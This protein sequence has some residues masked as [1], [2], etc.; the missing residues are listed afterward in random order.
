SAL[1]EAKREASV[2]RRARETVERPFDL[3]SGPLFTA[4]L[5]RLGDADHLLALATHH[6]VSDEWSKGVLLRE[7]DALYT[8]FSA[9]APSPLPAPALQ[10][11]DYAVWQRSWL[12][13]DTLERQVAYW[14]ERL[15][16]APPLLELPTD[17]PRP[18]TP[19]GRRA[20]HRFALPGE[21]AGALR[22]LSRREGATLFMTVFA[23]FQALL[24][25]HAG[26]EDVLVGTPVAGRG[27]AETEGL[28]G[29]FV[30]TLVLRADLSGDPAARALVAQTRERVL[31][32][33]THQDVPFE[34]LVD[35][36]RVERSLAHTPLFQVVF[37]LSG[38]RGRQAPRLGGLEVEELWEAAGETAFDLGLV[39]VEEEGRLVGEVDFRAALFDAATVERM[40]GHFRALLEGI[41]AHPER[42]VSDLPLLAPGER[43]QVV[44]G[45]G[46]GAREPRRDV[47]LHEWF[48]ERA[49]LAPDAVA[50]VDRGGTLTYGELAARAG[51]LAERLRA[52]GVGPEVRVG[53]CLERGAGAVAAILGV[54]TAG[55]AWVPLDPAYP[56][57]RL[58]FMLRDSGA[59]VVLTEA[60]LADRLP[61]FGGD[62][63]L[64]NGEPAQS[65]ALAPSHSPSPDPEGLAYVVY[66]SGSTGTPKGVMVSHRAAANLLA[67][68]L[69]DFGTG[70]GSRVLHAASLSFD[71]SVL[72]V[73]VALLAGAELH[74][75]DRETVLAAPALAALL[76]EHAIDTW[77]ATPALLESLPDADFPALRAV[78]TGGERCSA[79]VAARWSVGRRLV[80][81][82][83]PTETVVYT[84]RYPCRPGA[85]EAP[86]I[87]RPVENARAYVLD[88][89]G[90][91]LPAGVPGELYVG[92]AGVARGYLGRPDLTA[93]RFVPDPF[94]PEPRSGARAYRTGDRARW[95]PSGE[96]EFLGRVDR[97]VKLRG[98]RIEPGEVE[99]ALLA[100]PGVRSAA[101]TVRE[102]A[103]GGP[104]LV[105]YV[106]PEEGDAE[107]EQVAAWRKV[108]DETYE[109]AGPA[110]PD[111]GRVGW[112]PHLTP[113]E[114][115][116]EMQ[117]W[118]ERTAESILALKPERVLEIGCGAGLVLF[119]VAPHVRLYHATDISAVAVDELRRTAAGLPQ[120]R[121]GRAAADDL[122]ELAG[123]GFDTV[124]LNS[125]AQ[126][127][128]DVEYLLRVLEGAAAATGPG[129]R[130]FV[131][132]VH[133]LPLLRAFH[134]RVELA[135]TPDA[136]PLGHLRSR[137]RLA[138]AEEQELAID[139]ELFAALPRRIPR[140]GRV[141]VRTKRATHPMEV[142]RFSFDVVLHLDAAPRPVAPVLEWSGD[143]PGLAGVRAR[144]ES[145]PE[146]P[147]AVLGVPNAR[148][149]GDI[150]LLELLDAPDA[151]ATAGGLRAALAENGAPGVDPEALWTLAAELGRQVEIRPA[152]TGFLDVLFQPR[153]GTWA[154]A[155]PG[156]PAEA[157][158]WESYGNDPQRGRHRRELV[159]VLRAALRARLPEY[160]VPSAIV[161]L[162]AL[163]LTPT[164]KLDPGALPAP[165]AAAGAEHV[166][167][168]TPT[169]EILAGIFAEVLGIGRVGAHDNFFELGGHS[170]LAT[171][172]MARLVPA[173]GVELP[174]R[175]L[176]E[177]QTV[178]ELAARVEAARREGAAL[179]S[180]APPL[181]RVPRDAPLPLSF[182]QQR[183][184]F[185]D[186]LEPGSSAYNLPLALRLRGPLDARVLARTVAEIV[187]RHESLRTV[188]AEAG[189]EPVQVVLPAGPGALPVVDLAGLAGEAREAE[190]RRWV[191]EEARRPFDLERG[192]LLRA[193][194]LR[195]GGDEHVLLL[196]LHHIVSDGWSMGVLTRELSALYG[197]F[198]RGDPSPLPPLPVQ[199]ADYAVWQRSW[200]A[201]DALERQLA[202]WRERLAGAP[203]LLELPTDRP[204]SAAREPRAG[205][206]AFAVPAETAGALRA[207][208]RREA[209][210][211]FMA[212]LA[213]WQALLGR[214]AGQ[215]EVVVGSPIAGRTHVETEG[216]IGFF[217]NTLALRTELGGGLSFRALLGRVSEMTLGAYARQ[218]LPFEQVVEEL[219]P[220]RSLTHAPL[221]QVMFSLQSGGG[222]ELRLEGVR[223]EALELE[224]EIAKFDLSLALM[225]AEEGL[226]ASLLYRRALWDAATIERML[227]HFR[228]L[229]DAAVAD[230]ARPVDELP[231]LGPAELEQLRTEWRATHRPFSDDTCLHRLFGAQAGRTPDAVALAGG[232]AEV[233]YAELDR[234]ADRLAR[235]LR[236]R[237]VGPEVRVALLQEPGVEAVVSLLAVLKAGG[238]YVPL[239]PGSPPERLA[240]T[241]ADSGARLL[242]TEAELAGK[243]PEPGVE[244]V[245]VD[246]QVPSPG[247]GGGESDVRVS[248]Q[249]LAYVIYTSG[250]TG[251]PKGVL[252]P[253]RGVVNSVAA[254]T[255]IYGVGA[256]SRVLLFAPLHFDASVLDIFTTLCSGATLVVAPREELMP[257]DG[258]VELLRRERVTHLKITP[259]AL[260]VTP[261]AELPELEAVMVGGETCS[262]EL[263]ARWAPGRRLFNGYGATEHSVRFTAQR[264][265]DTTRPPP[266]GRPIANTRL[267]VLDAGLAPV[268]VGVA[269]EAYMAGVGVARGYLG[270][271]GL[272][273]ERFLP[274]P[275]SDEPGARMYRSG[276]RVRRR[277]DGSVEFLGRT[278]FQVKIRGFRIEPGEVEAAL[279]RHPGVR[280]AVV[281]ARG[282]GAGEARLVG[283]AVAAEPGA[284]PSAGELRAHL[285]AS[286]PEYMVPA[287]LVVLPELPLTP[288]GK[289]DRRALPAPEQA[290][291]EAYEAPRTPTEEVLAGIWAQVLDVERVGRDAGF[292]ALGGHSL[293]ATRVVSR[294]REAFG[295]EVPLRVL[296]EAPTV[297][298]L[299][300]RIDALLAEGAGVEAPPLERVARDGPLPLSFA[301]QRLWF[302]D[303]LEPGS[304]AYN[305][306]LALRLRGPL[307]ARVLARALGEV[308]RRHEALRTVFGEA[309][310]EPVQT[311]REAP[312]G[313]MSLPVVDLAGLRGEAREAEAR[314]RVEDEARR[315]F[316]L[317]RGPLLRTGLLR[318][319]A[320]EHVLLLSMH[321]IVSDGWS[322]GVLLGEVA[323]LYEAYARGE[324]SPLPELPVQY[325]DYAVWQR[326]W[327]AGDALER[328]LAWWRERL[329]GAPAVLEIPTD[330]P[331]SATPGARGAVAVRALP[332]AAA[333]RLRALSRAEGVTPFMTLLAG[334]DVLLARWSGQEDVVVGTPV[335]SRGRRE[336]EGLIGFFV[337][338][339]VLRT[340]VDGNPV[341]RGLLERVRETTLGAYQH[342]DL[343]FERLVEEMGV[344]RS[345]GHTPLFQVMFMLDDGADGVR[346]FGEV[347]AE[348]YAVGGEGVKFDLGASVSARGDELELALSY[349]EE[350]WDAA[351]MQRMLDAYALLLDA[352]AADPGRPVLHLPLQSDAERERVLAASSGPV[353]ALPG[354]ELVH[355]LVAAQAARTPGAPA[356]WFRG[357]TL[358]YAEL[359]RAANRL[360]HALRRRGVG[361]ESRVGIC[362]SRTPRLPV[363]LLGVLKAGG[364]YVPLDPEYP[365]ERL[366]Y[367]I[368]DAEVSLVLAESTLAD[369][370]P[371]GAYG[372]LVLDREDF[373][374]ESDEAPESGALPENLSHVIFTSGS[375]GRPKGVMVRHSSV[376]V[377]LYWLRRTV[378]DEERSSVLS[379]TSVNFDVSVA[380]IFG[381]LAWGGKLVLVENALELASLREPVVYASMVPTAAAELLRMG[382]VPPSLKTLNLAG[383]V[384]PPD[385]ARALY[386]LGTVE[387]V[388][389][390]Y[391]PTEDTTYST[392]ALVEP[393]A[394]Q[395]P[396]GRPVAG[397]RALVLDAE[398]QPVPVGVAG[399]LYLAGD[400]LTRGYA[401]RP[402][403]TAERYLPDPF[404]PPGSRMY[405]VMDRARWTAGGELEY[406]GRTDFQVK[407]RGFRVEPGEIESVL[408]AHPAVREAVAVARED[409][410]GERRL[411]AYLVVEPDATPPPAAELRAHLGARLPEYM[412]PS[413]FVTLGALPLTPSGK[414]DRGALPAPAGAVAEAYAAPRTPTEEVVA[415]TWASVLGVERVGR[416]AD[417]FVLGGH[418]LLATRVVARLRGAL[419]VELP[420]R[421]LFEA[422][423]AAG[424]AGR[425]DAL[426][427][428]GAGTVA[429]PV[430]RVPRDGSP[431]PLSFAQQR[432]WLVE[433]LEPGTAAYTLAVPLRLRGP[434]DPAAL[435]RALD[436]VVRRHEALRTV[437][438]V[439]DAD[440]VQVVRPAPQGVLRVVELAGLPRA[441]AEAE[442]RRL[443]D[444][445]AL[446]PFDL[447]RGP[448]FRA[449]LARIDDAEAALL[450]AMHHALSDG[451][452]VGVLTRELSALYSAFARGEPSP[453]PELP[454]QYA[455]YAVWQRAWLSGETLERQLAWW[456][457][458]LA[459]APPLLELP[460]D[461]PRSTVRDARGGRRHF[462]LD[463]ATSRAL[464]AL[465]RREGA[466]LFMTLLAAWQTLLARYSGQ[467]DVTVGTPIAGRTH[468]ELEGLI[469]FFVN[470]LA[471]RGDLSGD[472]PFREL[473][474]RVRETTLGAYGHQDLP[475]ERLV[476]ELGVER[477][478]THT[479]LFQAVLSL[480]N[481]DRLEMRL[482]E[483]EAEPLGADAVTARFDLVLALM[484]EGEEIH[485]GITY[486]A[487]LFEGATAERMLEHLRVLLQGIAADPD[488]RLSTLP[489]LAPA[490]RERVLHAPNATA[491]PFSADAC[492]HE[493]IEA[494][495]RR[496]PDAPAAACGG[497]TLTYAELD[498]RADD[499]ARGLR[500]RGV[501]PE[502]CV[503]LL[504]EPGLEMVVALL[505]VL[506]A[507]GAYVPLDTGSPTERL[508]W[509]LADCGARLVLTQAGLAGRVVGEGAEVVVLGGE[510]PAPTSPYLPGGG[511]SPGNL[512]YVIYTSGSTGRPK[513]VLVP[514]RGVVNS[515]EAY[516]RAY[517]IGPGSRVL[518]F[519]PLHFDASVL[520]I[521][522]ALCS[523]ATLVL[524]PREELMP[525]EG[526]VELLRR[527]RVTHLKITPSA[528]A[529]TPPAELPELEAVMV[530][531]E[532]CSG[533]LVARWAPGRRFFNGYG[534]T[535]HSVRCTALRCTDGTRPPPVGR[536]I[537]NA[538]LYVLDAGLEP[539]PVG[540]AGEVYMAG[541]GVTR[542]Y[543]NRAELTAERFVPDPY[544]GE[545][546]ARMYR[547]GDRGRWLA[548][549]TLEFVGRVD[550]QLKVRGYRIEPGEVEA[551]LLEHPALSDAVVV[552]R[553]DAAEARY[554]AA[555]AV[556][557]EGAAAPDAAALREH[558]QARLPE[559]LVPS[560]IVLLDRLPLTSNGKVDR[561]ALP[562]PAPAAAPGR[563]AYVPPRTPAEEVLAAVWAETLGVERVGAHDDFFALGGHSLAATRM[564]SRV[565][566]AFGVEAPLR[567]VFEAPV[568]SALAERI[569]T[570]VQRGAGV[571][572]PPLVR[573]PREAGSTF[574]LSFA[575]QRLWFIEQ[576][577]PE[578]ALYN[579]A[580]AFR[581]RGG[582]DVGAF[583]RSIDE[584]V[585]RHEALRTRFVEENG[586]PVQR[587]DPP[588]PVPLPLVDLG[589]LAP[590]DRERETK[591]LA[592]AEIRFR[593]DLR[594]GPILRAT[595]LRLADDDW[596]LLLTV[597]HVAFDGWSAGVF[598]AELST[599]YEDFTA[600][601]ESSLPGLPFQYADYAVWQRGWLQGEA[602]EQQLAWW[603]AQLAGA[604]P[605]LELPTDFPRPPVPGARATRLHFVVPEE[606][607]R[608]LHALV[609]KQ[610]ATLFMALLAAWQTLL[611]RYSGQDDVVVGAPIAG[612]RRTEL[613]PLVGFFVNTL[614]LR[615]N[616]SGDPAFRELLR[617]VR[618]T[619]LGAYQHQDIPFE[620][621]VEE[622]GVERSL[623]HAPVFQVMFA[624]QNLQ[625]A[626]LR[627]E[628]LVLEPFPTDAGAARNDLG[629]TVVEEGERLQGTLTYRTDLWEPA[630][631][632]RLLGHF[633]RLLDAVGAGPERRLS[634][635]ELLGDGERA[636]LLREWN[637][638]GPERRPRL[639]H[640]LFAEQA[641]RVPGALALVTG[642]ASLTYAELDARSDA[643]VRALRACGV[644]PEAR[645]AICLDRGPDMVA[646]V[647]AIL[648]AGGAYVPLD[649][650]YPRERLAYMLSDSGATVLLT[651]ERLVGALP[652]FGG[653]TVLVDR[654]LRSAGGSGEDDGEV[655]P[656]N[657]AYVIYTS[658]ST[659]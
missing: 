110:G 570:L 656:E 131:G 201:G 325:A 175:A 187:R 5:L 587:V 569:E 198:R 306:P 367:M 459:G 493:L 356:V 531:G 437:F 326:S 68:A 448:V 606:V 391:G 52:R 613:E 514:H 591:H 134:A 327:L 508:S 151:P 343:P 109:E 414:V 223:V 482:G 386:A 550:F 2:L 545:P 489:L 404:G 209:A 250:S 537:A 527:E 620:R 555:Y 49:A 623:S 460:T 512:A 484:E 626:A 58:A 494:Q 334:L 582:L 130:I 586:Q 26:Q 488:R 44:E 219:A 186:R 232:G 115:P 530:G 34:R 230:P 294:V 119:R 583:R 353:P 392:Y 355:D 421:A 417:F 260:A 548:D 597:H 141:A 654:A 420:L 283:Y 101:A 614:A 182:A 344:E 551:A 593:F 364:A 563:D 25:R 113:E 345:L 641:R 67:T 506:K 368:E 107:L 23:G 12:H 261:P 55:G 335:A 83:G 53:V 273:A 366:G 473:L 618:E 184:W 154:A 267:Y 253:H 287:A 592:G 629:I 389:N 117:E 467:E 561:R 655:S 103:P 195:L 578:A 374:G 92:G 580:Y 520:D 319:G 499:L 292:F 172:V 566:A 54:L 234:R 458:W 542:G 229:L 427:R 352:V 215:E 358:T 316:D 133:S 481:V 416:E 340:G 313:A 237:G 148:L 596:A 609:R 309:D 78:S 651:Q 24:S 248:P 475:F 143:G 220:E 375:T 383:E 541:V 562:A 57:E 535:E 463:A 297:A 507:G 430:V 633:L 206:V 452:S 282:D 361:P 480:Q 625:G 434:V 160:M 476:E 163:P 265:T 424:L 69:E 471:L 643:L 97:Q 108:W 622:L 238:A 558:L 304:T 436:E 204:R 37:S 311:V 359:D 552:A 177:A 504:L 348:P 62:V 88:P 284:A 376:V 556:P 72:E 503:A 328:R 573:A 447:G 211:P 372:I 17:R 144:L 227:G 324:P 213:A 446:R 180:A 432:L 363:A 428:A 321:H 577:D 247:T 192:P 405:R 90:N 393:G 624:V 79:E 433:Q 98:V 255:R 218:D 4:E 567:A 246:G 94:A 659:G 207:L 285:Q 299:A 158:S 560:A 74:V 604:P 300:E 259:S 19:G 31:E 96:L 288:N 333:A 305:V 221:F 444:A 415:G 39:V 132:D 146:A 65:R 295:A 20:T 155:F 280:D 524:A 241:L 492:L 13:G 217:V 99:A 438:A 208:V 162:D 194:L 168:R 449:T 43:A 181:A 647:L 263:V 599:L 9:G 380:E 190:A 185:I 159:P 15:A 251:Q 95:L 635:L 357:E 612:R 418:S 373:D 240:W 147:L 598:N 310:G 400:G 607:T 193:R 509:T 197:A 619:T 59:S 32:A 339:L 100:H 302:L 296:F 124:V 225:E 387:K 498:H 8:A 466:T 205:R 272:T 497:R 36:L 153:G 595:L 256:G 639:L 135:P 164:G 28:V 521:F 106:V 439:V 515:T 298:G 70:E 579:Q 50:V 210:T 171:R 385:L 89:R 224:A 46:A 500:A 242:L 610:G 549:G 252:V 407:V 322:V 336:I 381:A 634:E 396:I 605:L 286:L 112:N 18:R 360:A 590:A 93:E 584:E 425:V 268:P 502:V 398:L 236:A 349:R 465:S 191:E 150:R 435:G 111:F 142:S 594:R 445:E 457:E 529:V 576:L 505:G 196:A 258:L 557:R 176:F 140:I 76:R 6:V 341:F 397:T 257:G 462:A 354:G 645:V 329:A 145:A 370:L 589:V 572:L 323:A 640:D 61:A 116:G 627:L 513:G 559:H 608:G 330:R 616:L 646:G 511:P 128:P 461:R 486:R 601:R 156:A 564:I 332:A 275:F 536:P 574:P 167:P 183:L 289:V 47:C 166:P 152:A 412:V 443:A 41:V 222:E 525:G 121:V 291:G 249:N 189:G 565:R 161:L 274:D 235:A 157:R 149:A 455:D 350:L 11:A 538:R 523:G 102:D 216:L 642:D 539:V 307:D 3:E 378:S 63:V 429:P 411:V 51:R 637:P 254:F 403:L 648:R 173:L 127:F 301:Q 199:Y 137:V 600:G 233:T 228:V 114:M 382:A 320:D 516:A 338:T 451:W 203:P 453:L 585:R 91:P 188:F 649:P 281:V 243:V 581:L 178:A 568:L 650:E 315:P 441:A 45:W 636:Q 395:V 200:L 544:S 60:R 48:A 422:P 638:A 409:A 35:E 611:A 413:A 464:R 526:L 401:R 212:L 303:R 450:L 388:G 496:A 30:N 136:T 317:E 264:C 369:R 179:R 312:S 277:A 630:T 33:Q 165:D 533:E 495:A 510:A 80:N 314:R 270:R 408:R 21:L 244:V 377:L 479:P 245:V 351:T 390:A 534:A 105:A 226:R 81:M 553:G 266:L 170:L 85:A 410:P 440:P 632:Q 468:L 532:T 202:W 56:A 474:G 40:V 652:E 615:G 42:R 174:L 399:D 125:V 346:A 371:V 571:L 431:L 394:E 442:V 617:R 279:L 469:G 86:P 77:V 308:V 271:P 129:G 472:P 84:T 169:E 426:L 402:E 517:G 66:T 293:L 16:G 126:Y 318:L 501:G 71:A 75:A 64:L 365:R 138:L 478:L 423:T 87:G 104:A 543:L 519:A 22:G 342:Q 628:G 653:E 120:V 7:L 29:F 477:S 1:P 406:L 362:L 490:E 554:L 528:L 73:F 331:R 82:Y 575:Q 214:Y 491:A 14:R 419:G 379:S 485:G 38:A 657:L 644:R 118:V 603:R 276:D 483:A 522:T 278:D 540:V 27:R 518:L 602:L 658:G 384:L 139:P 239:D 231:L 547:S 631:M 290:P 123:A 456:R 337:N 621:L 262:G 454:C 347:E 10:Y 269:G 546:G 122:A 588:A 470:T 487:D